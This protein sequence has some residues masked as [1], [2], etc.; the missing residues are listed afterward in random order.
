MVV[1]ACK[2]I[3]LAGEGRLIRNSRSSSIIQQVGAI[4]YCMSPYPTPTL[5]RK[6]A[7]FSY[8]FFDFEI[9]LTCEL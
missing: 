3:T 9:K 6:E 8:L 5:N 2:P 7:T 1:H 4:L